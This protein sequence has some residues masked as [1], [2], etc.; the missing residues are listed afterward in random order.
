TSRPGWRWQEFL[1][2]AS[3]W[4]L[5]RSWLIWGIVTAVVYVALW[6]AMWVAPAT[7]LG[8][9]LSISSEYASEGHTSS[10]FFN[11]RIY[12]GDPGFWLYPIN[13]LWRTT[14]VVMV[15]LLLLL[16]ALLWRRS[17]A[18]RP[19]ILWTVVAM[20]ASAFFFG[21]FMTIG[22]KKF[23]RYLLPVFPSLD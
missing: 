22:A 14:P 7:T 2:G 1:S 17:L 20:L 5:L 12:N 19:V 10:I 6:P 16:G 13:Y 18:R 23:D 21:I 3:L 15:G 11:G 9:V 4:R 8:N